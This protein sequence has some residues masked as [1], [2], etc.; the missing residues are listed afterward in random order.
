MSELE[1]AHEHLGSLISEMANAGKIDVESYA[2]D[3]AHIYAHLNRA[4]NTRNAT[5]EV[6]DKEWEDGRLYPKDLEPLA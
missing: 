6:T 5:G 3:V 2:V 1:D 4:W